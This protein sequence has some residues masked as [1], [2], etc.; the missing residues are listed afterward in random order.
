MRRAFTLLEILVCIA[1]VTI[2]MAILLPALENVRHQGYI[3]KCASNLHSIGQALAIYANENHGAFPRTA[4]VPGAPI[5]FGT[6]PAA[7]DPFLAGGPVANDVTAAVFLLM[8]SEKM[9]PAVFICPYYDVIEYQADSADIDNRSNFTNEKINLGYSFADPY[10]DTPA[11]NAGYKWTAS[12]SADL[13]IAADRNPGTDL[14]GDDVI[15]VSATSAQ[16]TLDRGNS[17]NHEKDGQNV[18]FGDGHVEWE[19]TVF[20][21]VSGDNIFANQNNLLNASPVTKDDSLLLPTD[22]Q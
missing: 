19:R 12:L 8:R 17:E 14:P 18:L 13:A 22:E 2:L 15:N 11:V 21:G 5:T 1:I 7:T 10:P 4:Y 9:P 6:N 16:D 3:D 20:C